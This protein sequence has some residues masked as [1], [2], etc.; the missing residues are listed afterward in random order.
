MGWQTKNLCMQGYKKLIMSEINFI[1][2]KVCPSPPSSISYRN[3]I[4]QVNHV[5]NYWPLNTNWIKC[6]KPLKCLDIVWSC[7]VTHWL[8]FVCLSISVFRLKNIKGG[9]PKMLRRFPSLPWN[10]PYRSLSNCLIYALLIKQKFV[11]WAKRVWRRKTPP[12][13]KY[14]N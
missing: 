13:S 2:L 7:M 14:S 3:K 8:I 4:P 6:I 9:N 12:Q 10:A 11:Q 1:Y 5:N